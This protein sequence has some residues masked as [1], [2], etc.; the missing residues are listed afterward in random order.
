MLS[1]QDKKIWIMISLIL[2]V[3]WIKENKP[4]LWTLLQ[5]KTQQPFWQRP[6]YQII[7]PFI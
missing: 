4:I 6:I 3:R 1:R 5:H 2:C 7:H